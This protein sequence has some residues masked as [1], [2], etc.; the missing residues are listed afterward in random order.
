[1]QTNQITSWQEY[2]EI[3]KESI[4]SPE[5]FWSKIAVEFTCHKKWDEVLSWEFETPKVEWFKGGKLNITENLLDRNTKTHPEKIA[6]IW[7]PNDPRW[8][9]GKRG[10][11]I[12]KR[13]KVKKHKKR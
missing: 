6:L 9:T 10:R 5:D 3:Y 12:R 11:K 13:H 8:S 4:E 1:M 7:E 2:E